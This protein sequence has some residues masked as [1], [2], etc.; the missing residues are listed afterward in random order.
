MTNSDCI[1]IDDDGPE[2][3]QE[4]PPSQQAR[5]RKAA[6]DVVEVAPP[7]AP[8]MNNS[9]ELEDDEEL[10]M[11]GTTGEGAKRGTRALSRLALLRGAARR[12][13]LLRGTGGVRT[14]QRMSRDA[15]RELT[16][17]CA[18]QTR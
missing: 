9:T 4:A 7:T 16:P 13:H 17:L 8:Q 5:K 1:V 12:L 3:V 18:A 10:V 15:T 14:K 11:V 2:V 6:D